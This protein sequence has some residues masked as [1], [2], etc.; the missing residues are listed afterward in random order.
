MYPIKET[1]LENKTGRFEDIRN[2]LNKQGF[3]VGGNWEYDHGYFDRKMEDHPS[4][5]FIRVP[6][7][8]EKGSFGEDDAQVRIGTPLVLRHKYQQKLDD[9]VFVD[10]SNAS[11][12]QF[13]EP[14]DPDA[15]LDSNDIEQAMDIIRHVEQAADGV[16]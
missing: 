11:F 1:K 2:F 16:I 14:V 13:S 10:N 6:I 4:Y 9:F 5:L 3:D 7:M 8:V 15:A 12:N